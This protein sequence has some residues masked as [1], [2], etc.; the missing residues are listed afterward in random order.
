MGDSAKIPD[1]TALPT[2]S[3]S[4][5][6]PSTPSTPDTGA[7]SAKT[8]N[9]VLDT[10]LNSDTQL[11]AY[12]DP[13]IASIRQVHTTQQVMSKMLT[14]E[15]AAILNEVQELRKALDALDATVKETM[16]AKEEAKEA[17]ETKKVLTELQSMVK[18][19]MAEKEEKEK[20][21]EEVVVHKSDDTA[22]WALQSQVNTLMERDAAMQK[23]MKE[24]DVAMKAMEERNKKEIEEL[25]ALYTGR[26]PRAKLVPIKEELEEIEEGEVREGT[27][28]RG[29]PFGN[30]APRKYN[31]R[32]IGDDG[33]ASGGQFRRTRGGT[34]G[35][36][37]H[38]GVAYRNY[39][40]DRDGILRPRLEY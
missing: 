34:G 33:R 5:F 18:N 13:V 2:S 19:M 16:M 39:Y 14:G 38:R 30:P 8:T 22:V 10:N 29:N 21:K 27:R 4:T 24:R 25:S 6:N 36:R 28:K 9:W 7:N 31:D 40:A 12:M 32:H 15:R 3:S 35:G 11:N 17:Q 20:D 1:L 37:G 23:A 26:A